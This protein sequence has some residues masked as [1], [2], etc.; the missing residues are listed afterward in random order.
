MGILGL[1]PGREVGEAMRF[2]LELRLDEGPL[3]PEEA[4]RAPAGVVGRSARTDVVTSSLRDACR[5]RAIGPGCD[6]LGVD[7]TEAE[8]LAFADVDEPQGLGAEPGGELGAAGVGLVGDLDHGAADGAGGC[9]AA[10][11]PR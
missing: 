4:E 8:L 2:L 7:P 1:Q 6:D 3:E 9:P 5:R 11:W 10:G